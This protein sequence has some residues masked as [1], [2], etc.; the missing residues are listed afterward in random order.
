MM[1]KYND[2]MNHTG[3]EETEG[4]KKKKKYKCLS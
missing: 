4:E 1:Q 3:R 2:N